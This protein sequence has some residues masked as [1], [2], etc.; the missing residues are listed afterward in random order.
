MFHCFLSR[1]ANFWIGLH[2]FTSS[3][4]ISSESPCH[5]I[6]PI[7][8][9]RSNFSR[10]IYIFHRSHQCKI[11]II[12]S[13]LYFILVCFNAFWKVVGQLK[14]SID[15]LRFCNMLLMKG[16]VLFFYCSIRDHLCGLRMVITETKCL[17]CTLQVT[18][19]K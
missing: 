13:T 17:N 8:A 2:L 15:Q 18:A 9:D 12:T 10:R 19:R 16:L 7:K 6:C 5:L 3:K 4:T 11:T 14:R 1:A